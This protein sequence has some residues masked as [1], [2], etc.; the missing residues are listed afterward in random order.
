MKRI[1]PGRTEC[2][3]ADDSFDGLLSPGAG[4]AANILLK[5]E[6]GLEV[7]REGTEPLVYSSS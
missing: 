6:E 7:L 2:L 1:C 4:E 5:P 3:D